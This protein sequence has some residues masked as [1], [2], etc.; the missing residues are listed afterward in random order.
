MWALTSTCFSLKLLSKSILIKSAQNAKYI[1]GSKRQ[2]GEWY[3]V[4]WERV[5]SYIKDREEI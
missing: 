1:I 3:I 5:A 2:K 4:S